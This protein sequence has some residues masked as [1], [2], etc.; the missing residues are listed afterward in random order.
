MDYIVSGLDNMVLQHTSIYREIVS[1]G[2]K[3]LN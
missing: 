1:N 2:Q 3:T